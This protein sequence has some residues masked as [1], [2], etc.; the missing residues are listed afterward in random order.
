MSQSIL[1]TY[2]T[3]LMTLPRY[4]K[5]KRGSLGPRVQ[6]MTLVAMADPDKRSY[7]GGIQAV[8][9]TLSSHGDTH[10]LQESKFPSR[11]G[12]SQKRRATGLQPFTD[13]FHQIRSICN[14]AREHQSV[15]FYGHRL[16]SIDGTRLTLPASDEL[17]TYFGHHKTGK[18]HISRLPMAGLNLL[19]DTSANQPIDWKLNTNTLNEREASFEL[20]ENISEGDVLL[21]DRGY[22]SL[23]FFYEILH[24]QA[25][26][27]IRVN[28]SP[29]G[30]M[31]E[32]SDFLESDK[33]DQVIKW[34][35]KNGKDRRFPGE[36]PMTIRLIRD[37]EHGD[38]IIA[39]S[40]TKRSYKRKDILNAYHSRWNIETAIRELKEWHGLENLKS[41]WV[42]GIRQEVTAIMTFLHLVGE[43]EAEM[44][45]KAQELVEEGSQDPSILE[46]EN[47]PTFNRRLMIQIA[48]QM[49]IAMLAGKS[50]KYFKKKW[51]RD[52][53]YLWRE[54]NIRRKGRSYRRTSKSPFGKW[55][56]TR[57]YSERS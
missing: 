34:E 16:I 28:T 23:N 4:N 50:P 46:P 18:N 56:R 54:R 5:R 43:M 45:K 13:G 36:K 6:F 38:R 39:T 22:P 21:A 35:P 33:D 49:L 12:F 44:K 31:K 1:N 3:A 48:A 26:F 55:R 52:S 42:D 51:E 37:R 32:V 2:S 11:S 20:I 27:I 8:F 47:M 10:G 24:R 7:S 29:V 57:C 30:L 9:D 17:S 14:Y 19:W 15:L 25:D 40:L 53:D 41:Q